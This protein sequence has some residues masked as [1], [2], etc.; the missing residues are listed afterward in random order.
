MEIEQILQTQIENEAQAISYLKAL[1]NK[2]ML[3]NP[4]D[5]ASDIVWNKTYERVF[6][7]TQA[8]LYDARMEEVFK[9]L[10]DPHEI[11]MEIMGF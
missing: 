10:A 2:D 9:Y 4:D 5:R 11:C 7:D 8:K 6:D 3:F 1:H